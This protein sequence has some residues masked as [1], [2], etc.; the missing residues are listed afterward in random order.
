M[1][2]APLEEKNSESYLVSSYNA[3]SGE[4]MQQPCV[5]SVAHD[6]FDCLEIDVCGGKET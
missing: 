6:D 1:G 3:E 5:G 4:S 2:D